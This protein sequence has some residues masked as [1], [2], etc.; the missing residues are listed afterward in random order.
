V[1]NEVIISPLPEWV[2]LILDSGQ[3]FATSDAFLSWQYRYTLT[4]T[5][6]QNPAPFIN[7]IPA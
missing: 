7:R 4:L 6:T 3:L 2:R 5:L 1:V